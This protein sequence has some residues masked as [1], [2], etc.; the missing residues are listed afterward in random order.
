MYCREK[1][2][3]IFFSL[4][5]AMPLYL[6]YLLPE[7]IFTAEWQFGLCYTITMPYPLL[8]FV[9]RLR[10]C[11]TKNWSGD[12]ISILTT[13]MSIVAVYLNQVENEFSQAT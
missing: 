11:V 10:V 12:S 2:R 13:W 7:K 8:P 1:E 4:E 3:N 6:L 5:K 9:I